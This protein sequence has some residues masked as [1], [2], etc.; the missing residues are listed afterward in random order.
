MKKIKALD[1]ALIIDVVLLVAFSIA[2]IVTF[3]VKESIPD[4][5]V[6]SF[7]TVCGFECGAAASITN[8][9]SKNKQLEE[10]DKKIQELEEKLAERETDE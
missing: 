1:I 6:V 5:L 9:K 10:K 4:T 7:F 2:M 3:W 8:A